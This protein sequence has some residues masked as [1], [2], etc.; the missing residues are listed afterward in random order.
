MESELTGLAPGDT[1]A[2]REHVSLSDFGTFI[3]VQDGD[4]VSVYNSDGTTTTAQYYSAFSGWYDG[5]LALQ[6]DLI[7]FPGE[8]VVINSVTSREAIFYGSVNENLTLAPF[9]GS[10][11][12][13][14]V[15]T[16]E[17]VT[18]QT[19][20]ETFPNPED[21]TLVSVFAV[22]SLT[23]LFTAQY[24]SAFNGWFDGGLSP[25]DDAVIPAASAV[26]MKTS[27]EGNA[28]HNPAN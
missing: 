10:N 22:G 19:L 26:V 20:S 7:I 15:G 5:G 4:L 27:L 2:I 6:D 21:G 17:P 3:N 23:P 13:N 25:Q 9:A 24:Y 28:N 11:I 8:G 12:I 14:I 18:G 16:L 1:I